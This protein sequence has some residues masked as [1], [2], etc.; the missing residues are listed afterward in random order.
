MKV[1]IPENINNQKYT[2]SIFF[3]YG[4]IYMHNPHNDIIVIYTTGV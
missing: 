3:S 1:T 2:K 4:G